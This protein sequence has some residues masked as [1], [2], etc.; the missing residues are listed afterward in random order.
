[1]T[2]VE[3]TTGVGSSKCNG[4]IVG[5]IT[6][7]NPSTGEGAVKSKWEDII[8]DGNSVKDLGREGIYFI[9]IGQ[10]DGDWRN[11]MLENIIH[12]HK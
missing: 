4:G 11:R 2:G 12:R 10:S 3:I 6:T 7:Q 9:L 8:I 1:M 5:K